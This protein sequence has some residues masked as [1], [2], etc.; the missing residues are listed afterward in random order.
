MG[1]SRGKPEFI[2]PH[3]ENERV[4]GI[5]QKADV[6]QLLKIPCRKIPPGARFARERQGRAYGAVRKD[7]REAFLRMQK[8][9]CGTS[10]NKISHKHTVS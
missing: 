5:Y 10:V 3:E 7:P 8:M 4:A 1:R 9:G 6:P 2:F